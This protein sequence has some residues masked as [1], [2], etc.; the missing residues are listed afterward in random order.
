MP[1]FKK[2]LLHIIT[3]YDQEKLPVLPS[4][5]PIFLRSATQLTHSDLFRSL[6]LSLSSVLTHARER[7]A[8]CVFVIEERNNEEHDIGVYV[9]ASATYVRR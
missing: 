2:T 9:G 7:I 6:S 8:K 3:T 4:L 1:P 5:V